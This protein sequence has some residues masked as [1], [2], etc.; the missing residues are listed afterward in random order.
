M[1][2]RQLLLSTYSMECDLPPNQIQLGLSI[3]NKSVS[4]IDLFSNPHRQPKCDM[5][6]LRPIIV[7]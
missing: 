2:K 6:S 7:S 4:V 3:T 5:L 1:R